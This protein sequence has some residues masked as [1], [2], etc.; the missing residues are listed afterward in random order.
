MRTRALYVTA[1]LGILTAA[2]SLAQSVSS[3]DSVKT[4][5]FEASSVGRALKYNIVLPPNYAASAAR[6][7]VLY[8]LHG[9]S[10]NYT[11]WAR[12]NAPKFAAAYDLIVVMPDA[13]NSWYL[14]WV[15]VE[16][17]RK[18]NWEDYIVSDLIPHIDAT[19]RTIDAREGRAI[20][21]LS[22]GGYGALMLGL[23]HPDKFC[24]IGSHSGALGFA[25]SA[26][27]GLRSG[28][29]AAKKAR[30]KPSEEPNPAIGIEGFNSQAE[31]TPKG[32]L[33]ATAEQADACDPFKLVLSVPREKLPHI[34]VDCGTEDRLLGSSR[35]FARLLM[36]HNLPFTYAESA[37]GHNG[38]YWSREVGLSMAVQYQILRRAMANA[39]KGSKAETP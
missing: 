13:G 22:M 5:Q 26:A 19:F 16:D 33:F 23:K 7:P 21:G 12:H 17:G 32:K 30:R 15:E 9:Y 37:G 28:E 29:A 36:D 4:V 34:Y 27:E 18:D 38:A 14:N 11:N 25:R 10:G 31:R 1:V 39:E 6:Y 24:A 3:S 35:D 20:N 2:S 8:L